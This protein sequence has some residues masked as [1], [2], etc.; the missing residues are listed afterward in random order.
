MKSREGKRSDV[1][2]KDRFDFDVVDVSSYV[3]AGKLMGCG[4]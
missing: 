2:E 4:D 3:S 1:R